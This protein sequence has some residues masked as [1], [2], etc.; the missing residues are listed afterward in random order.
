MWKIQKTLN[1]VS[2]TLEI[3]CLQHDRLQDSQTSTSRY[4]AWPGGHSL[5]PNS[6]GLQPTTLEETSQGSKTIGVRSIGLAHLQQE[7]TSCSAINEA[8]GKPLGVRT[9]RDHEDPELQ[10]AIFSQ[11]FLGLSCGLV[12]K[13]VSGRIRT[14]F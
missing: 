2:R 11:D 9:G 5:Q 6:D 1:W 10:H 4:Q 3:A 14:A 7:T 12:T 13:Y 8:G